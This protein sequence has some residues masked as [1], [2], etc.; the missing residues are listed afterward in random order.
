MIYKDK[1]VYGRIWHIFDVT[2][3]VKY[4]EKLKKKEEQYRK[5][6]N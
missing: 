2:A 5:F 1:H 3:Q 4:E 6:L